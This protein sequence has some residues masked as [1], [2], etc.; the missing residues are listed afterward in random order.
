MLA[1]ALVF[2]ALLQ[3][4]NLTEAKAN[5]IKSLKA[6]VH[7]AT[8]MTNLG[9]F[10]NHKNDI[11]VK[12][13]KEGVEVELSKD[14]QQQKSQ[15]NAIDGAN[16]HGW[17]IDVDG[18][19]FKESKF[20]IMC[21]ASKGLDT[22][23][24]VVIGYHCQKDDAKK[25]DPKKD[26]KEDPKKDAKEDPKK[27]GAKEDPK[28]DGAKEDPKPDG[29]KERFSE[30]KDKSKGVDAEGEPSP[31][32]P[33]KTGY[34]IQEDPSDCCAKEFD[35]LDEDDKNFDPRIR[36]WHRCQSGPY[37]GLSLCSRYKYIA[38]DVNGYYGC[39]YMTADGYCNQSFR[40]DWVQFDPN[41]LPGIFNPQ[42]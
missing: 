41:D 2:A 7:M 19:R 34:D 21:K 29:A 17:K 9:P 36:F 11:Y 24:T 42:K 15:W 35:E 31:D 5:K 38:A 4:L 10:K 30:T 25:E 18:L 40:H 27:D 23:E 6:H 33:I 37:N 22:D 28:P 14:K 1:K 39:S 8:S 12:I 32:F 26:A 3:C 13:A 16:V 20:E